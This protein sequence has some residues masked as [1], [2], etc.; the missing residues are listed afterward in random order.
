MLRDNHPEL[1][2]LTIRHIDELFYSVYYF[3][4]GEGDDLGWLG[5]FIGCS[6]HLQTLHIKYLPQERGHIEA[7]MEG[8]NRNRS[9]KNFKIWDLGGAS[10]RGL[11]TFFTS[12]YN[13]GRLGLEY[14]DVGLEC[15]QSIASVLGESSRESFTRLDFS[16]CN[17]SDE[18]FTEIVTALSIQPQLEELYFE[19]NNICSMGCIALGATL[20][21]WQTSN[22]RILDLDENAIDD[23][24][25]EALIAGITNTTLKELKLSHNTMIT[26]AGLRSLRNYFQSESC[27][28]SKLAL[29]G[30]DFGD[31]GAVAL[32]EGLTRNKS[33]ECLYFDPD[34]PGITITEVG[35]AAFSTLLCDPSTINSA[36]LS[37]HNILVIGDPDDYEDDTDTP[38]DIKQYLEWNRGR[39]HQAAICKIL[40]SQPDLDMKPFFEWKL[41]FLP[42]VMSWFEGARSCMRANDLGESL[43]SVQSRQLSAVY[44]FVREMPDLVMISYWQQ[45][46]VNIQAQKR[47]LDDEMRRLDVEEDAAWVRLGGRSKNERSTELV[48]S[49][50]K[51]VRQS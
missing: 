10:F 13:L 1:I 33:L 20:R 9:I 46:I 45:L 21:G 50:G 35:W 39:P 30:I 25:L 49:V 47:R 48:R 16:R 41:K 14:F 2:D 6:E 40:K 38:S 12:N 44:K 7:F 31:E 28:L 15:A 18:G 32:A 19:G 42:L 3:V 22:L 4:I 26:G 43:Q 37:N 11:C 24:G 34:D 5:Y 36:Y 51:R 27:T 29:Y 8:I 23:Q 17:L